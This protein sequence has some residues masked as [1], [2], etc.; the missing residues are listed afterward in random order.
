MKFQ[1]NNPI[2]L[3]EN[4]TQKGMVTQVRRLGVENGFVITWDNGPMFS[5]GKRK[6]YF[7]KK[8]DDLEM[9]E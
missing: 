6:A 7:G 9:D 5:Q 4:G 8:A 1:K 3:K 2:K